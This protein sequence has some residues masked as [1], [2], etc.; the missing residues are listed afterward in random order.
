MNPAPYPADIRAK[1]WRFELDYEQIEQS[2]TWALAG[3]ECR[4][5]LLMMWMTAWRQVPCGSLPGDHEVVAACLG[6]P[7]KL[8]SKYSKTLLRGWALADDGRM[9]HPTITARVVEMIDSPRTISVKRP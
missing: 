8:W 3:A 6:M 5:W 4:P 1:G 2:S 7:G 9:Y